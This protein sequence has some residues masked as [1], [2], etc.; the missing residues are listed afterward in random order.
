MKTFSRLFFLLLLALSLHPAQA[1]GPDSLRLAL[2]HLFAPLDKTQVPVPY[3]YE[4]GNRFASATPF[5]GSLTDSS[6]ATLTA[7]RL[8]YASVISGNVGRP[9][10]LRD[11]G[12][13]T[14]LCLAQL[15]ASND[16]AR[17]TNSPSTDRYRSPVS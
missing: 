13:P 11:F 15:R 14:T 7:W 1:Q 17:Q 16:L 12:H 8:L 5:N 10:P 2:D 9:S 4:Y 3:L 6:V